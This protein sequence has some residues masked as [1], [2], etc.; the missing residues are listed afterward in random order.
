MVSLK[1]LLGSWFKSMLSESEES[2]IKAVSFF[3]FVFADPLPQVITVECCYEAPSIHKRRFF[4]WWTN[5]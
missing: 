1:E 5:K 2:S 3:F 4:K